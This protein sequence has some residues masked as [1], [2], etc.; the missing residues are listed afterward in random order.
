MDWGQGIGSACV[1][2]PQEEAYR[3]WDM[4]PSLGTNVMIN[5]A[6]PMLRVV[7]DPCR[8]GAKV[9]SKE[10]T[11]H[12][13]FHLTSLVAGMKSCPRVGTRKSQVTEIEGDRLGDRETGR[14]SRVIWD[15]RDLLKGWQLE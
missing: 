9:H 1:L 2:D 12:N 7:E 8:V 3:H 5:I 6:E 10:I 11:P 4:L 15:D 14:W 13:G